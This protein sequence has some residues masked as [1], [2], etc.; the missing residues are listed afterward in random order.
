MRGIEEILADYEG[1]RVNQ[2]DFYR[3]LHQHPEL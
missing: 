3:D 2:E 1:L